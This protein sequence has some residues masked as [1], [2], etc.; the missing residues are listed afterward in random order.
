MIHEFISVGP[1]GEHCKQTDSAS[2]ISGGKSLYKIN[3]FQLWLYF[4]NK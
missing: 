1:H 2:E 3:T 4:P